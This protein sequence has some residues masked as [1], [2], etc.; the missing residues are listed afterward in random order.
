LD[1]VQRVSKEGLLKMSGPSF[2]LRCAASDMIQKSRT[3]GDQFETSGAADQQMN[4]WVSDT[5]RRKDR[6]VRAD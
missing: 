6:G 1:S 2:F 5:D 4:W 3:G